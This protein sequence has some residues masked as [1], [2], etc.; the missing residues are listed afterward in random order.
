MDSNQRE[1]KKA[2]R[3]TKL[4]MGIYVV[5]CEAAGLCF[6]G[7]G[8]NLKGKMNGTQFQ[9]QMGS[10]P[11]KELQQAWNERQGEGFVLEVLDTLEYDKDET[12]TDYKE[13]LQE[14]RDMWAE[15]LKTEQQLRVLV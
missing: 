1:L 2:Y 5:R 8:A 15:K 10:H 12:K 11:C 3:E 14:L 6:V 4:P 13:E 7:W 9:L